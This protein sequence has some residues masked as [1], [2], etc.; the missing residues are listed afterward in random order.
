MRYE[1]VTRFIA[2]AAGVVGGVLV[3]G[4]VG[5]S[6]VLD[7]AFRGWGYPDP[8]PTP[9]RD[10]N[11]PTATPRPTPTPTLSNLAPKPSGLMVTGVTETTVSLSWD[12]A[13]GPLEYLL[14]RSE[15]LTEYLFEDRVVTTDTDYTDSDMDPGKTYYFRVSARGDG[16]RYVDTFGNPSVI[17]GITTL[18]DDT[19]TPQP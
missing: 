11:A 15:V 3:V 4:M 6:L 5:Y 13:P 8:T 12:S 14:E 19:T 17:V 10:P 2:I 9:T 1:K 16:T 7:Q 18:P